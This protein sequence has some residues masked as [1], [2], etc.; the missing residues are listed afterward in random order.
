MTE[1]LISQKR[2]D[3]LFDVSAK[4]VHMTV[5]DRIPFLLIAQLPEGE[6]VMTSNMT[7]EGVKEMLKDLGGKE[8]IDSLREDKGY[9]KNAQ[10]GSQDPVSALFNVPGDGLPLGDNDIH[11]EHDHAIAP[12]TEKAVEAAS[13][14]AGGGGDYAGAGASG[15]WDSGSSSSDS[16]SSASSS[17]GD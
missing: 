10:T 7:D 1:P 5:Q 6:I 15:S 9:Y 8:S 11:T 14:V 13:P 17:S 12:T 4:L 3:T 2:A 16:G